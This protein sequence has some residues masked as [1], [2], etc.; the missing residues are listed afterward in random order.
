MK[1]III[2]MA[3]VIAVAIIGGCDTTGPGIHGNFILLM[4]DAPGEFDE[5]NI[6]IERVDVHM[7]EG[8]WMTIN[9]TPATYDL[10]KLTNGVMATLGEA[11]LEEGKYTMIRLMIGEGSNVVVDS[12]E[13]DLFIPSGLQTGI[14]L[15]QSFDIA[16][17]YTY[18]LLIDFDAHRSVVP[19]AG[20]PHDYILQPT[21]RVQPIAQSG[22]I[23]GTVIPPEARAVVTLL[24]EDEIITTT[25]AD[26]ESGGFKFV[27]VPAGEYSV[28]A[29]GREEGYNER[30]IDGVIVAVGETTHIGNIDL[31]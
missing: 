6:V 24:I 2:A 23:S 15:V 25:Y 13:Y 5:V 4:T 10:L 1:Y 18:E 12:V 31:E 30:L 19:V 20:H 8:T 17:D 14:Q 11:K 16:A 7:A 27:Y 28:H 9:N 29:E 21:Y 22:S 3:A 26:E